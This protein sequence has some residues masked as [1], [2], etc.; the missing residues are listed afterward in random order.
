MAIVLD[1][2]GSVLVAG[3]VIVLGLRMNMTMSA[4]TSASMTN[5]NIQEAMV[6][7]T[8]SI[9]SDLKKMGYG[10]ADPSTAI[11]IGDS[12]RIRFRADM[13]PFGSIDSVEWYVGSR[14][15]KYTDRDVR[16]L[17]R[18]ANNG[19]AAIAA[20]GVTRFNLKYLDQNGTITSDMAQVSMI[21]MTLAISSLYKVA[22]Q[23]KSDTTD[24]V[25]TQWRLG[26]LSVRNI[27][28]HG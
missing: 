3:Y 19:T 16:I 4:T 17:Y 2:L 6:T 23:L 18:K 28:R 9:E 26:R 11:A 10:L 7:T 1:L 15:A 21:E 25:T 12:N 27:V 13:K 14:L 22:D 5:V 24:Y 8:A 20:I